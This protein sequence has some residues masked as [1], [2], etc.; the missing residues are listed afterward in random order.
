M[1]PR[2]T[3]STPIQRRLRVMLITSPQSGRET[4]ATAVRPT[5]VTGTRPRMP[6]EV[7][8]ARARGLAAVAARARGLAAV[9]ARA[10]GFVA[11]AADA[12]LFV[13]VRALGF[14][15]V[16]GFAGARRGFAAG[17]A[18]LVLVEIAGAPISPPCPLRLPR[19]CVPRAG[20]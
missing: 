3:P 1:P 8:A 4:T 13:A 20:A 14:V 5:A 16:R 17:R 6:G 19:A 15:A 7:V 9:V 12:R 10:F 11:V 18:G 2:R